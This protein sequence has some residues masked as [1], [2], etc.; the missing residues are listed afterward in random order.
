M[1]I[2]LD[3]QG[4]QTPNTRFRGIGRYVLSLALAIA[5]NRGE[6]EIFIALNGL[7]PESIEPIRAA[8]DGILPQEHIRVWYSAN[9]N[10][11]SHQTAE[12]IHEA[13]LAHLKPDIVLVGSF[14]EGSNGGGVATSIGRLSKTIPVAVVMHDLI[15]LVYSEHYLHDSKTKKW[16]FKKLESLGQADLL[17]SN[18]EHSRQEALKYL[19][20]PEDKIVNISSAVDDYFKPIKVNNAESLRKRY[21]LT[22]PFVLYTGGIDF[23]KN[24]DGLIR[25]YAKLPLE[26]RNQHQL[27]I[28]C[29]ITRTE[30]KNFFRWRPHVVWRLTN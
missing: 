8:F 29:S 13:F 11:W 24:I 15:P 27:V 19:S 20:F 18:S 22:H 25:A 16:Y 6:H 26:V 30:K 17:L 3:L 4:A 5:R 2:V 7:F 10:D 23:R 21:G 14:F 28:V 9:E 12:L 1:R